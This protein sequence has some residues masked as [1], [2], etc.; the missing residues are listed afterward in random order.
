MGGSLVSGVV[1]SINQH[2]KPVAAL[3]HSS[4]PARVGSV[5][6]WQICS[7]CSTGTHTCQAPLWLCPHSTGD[8]HWGCYHLCGRAD[9]I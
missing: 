2:Q 4:A 9:L 8:L 7:V 1:R 5:L 6:I 3:N